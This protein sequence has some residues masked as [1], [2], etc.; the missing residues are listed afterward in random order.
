MHPLEKHIDSFLEEADVL[1]NSKKTYKRNLAVFFTW[2][3][4]KQVPAYMVHKDLVAYKEWLRT[5]AIAANTS[6]NYLSSVKALFQWLAQKG[7][8]QNIAV[9]LKTFR[10]SRSG[11]QKDALNLSDVH[12]LFESIAQ[13]TLEGKRDFALLNLLVRA[14]LRSIEST[15]L[16]WGDMQ[17]QGD[18]QVLWVHG[19]GRSQKDEWVVLTEEAMGPLHEWRQAFASANVSPALTPVKASKLKPPQITAGTPIF[20]SLSNRNYGCPMTTRSV[21][22][23]VKKY[24]RDI[25]LDSPRLSCHSLRHTAI[26]LALQGGAPIRAVQKM[27]R[28]KSVTTTE[29]YAH[30]LERLENP[31]EEY[32]ERALELTSRVSPKKAS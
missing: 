12:A 10:G 4:Q 18:T 32:V 19:K 29:I 26:T 31:A 3:E 17:R 28:H 6:A 15:R 30:D 20:C 22:R 7:I 13:D 16:C 2:A 1:S 5:R 25:D 9:H 23:I 24:L 11:K 21:R 27:A 14:G 8:H